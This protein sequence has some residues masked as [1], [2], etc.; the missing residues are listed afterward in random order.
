MSFDLEFLIGQLRHL[1][2]SRPFK[3]I[4]LILPILANR[5]DHTY[6]SIL[7]DINWGEN[8]R[9][10]VDTFDTILAGTSTKKFAIDVTKSDQRD[11]DL[12]CPADFKYR[13][14]HLIYLDQKSNEIALEVTDICIAH[15]LLMHYFED[16]AK[17]RK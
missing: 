16:V 10:E 11:L 15:P 3:A 17:V 2:Q 1:F 5:F 6:N 7:D 4:I 12:L 9:I 13:N 14:A 8:F